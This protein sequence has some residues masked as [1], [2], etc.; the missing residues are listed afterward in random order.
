MPFGKTD[1]RQDKVKLKKKK[2]FYFNL[3]L[4]RS[5]YL[6]LFGEYDALLLT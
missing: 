4:F 6:V 3:F 5:C 2:K 1:V